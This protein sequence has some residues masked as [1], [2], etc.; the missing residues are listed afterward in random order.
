MLKILK[1]NSWDWIGLYRD[2]KLIWEGHSLTPETLLSLLKLDFVVKL[3]PENWLEDLGNC[4]KDWPAN[5]RNDP[6]RF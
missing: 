1:S 3:A 2:D 6:E 4:P 5:L